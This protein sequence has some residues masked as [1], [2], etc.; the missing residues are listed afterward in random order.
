MDNKLNQLRVLIVDR[1]VHIRQLM[2][3]ILQSIGAQA[4]DMANSAE[5]AFERY[6]T[7]QYDV[8]FTDSE[9]EPVSGLDLVD[10]I[11]GSAKSPNPYVPIIMLSARSDVDYVRL[12]RDHGVTEFLAKPF[13]VDTVM[14]HV[15]AI[16]E[17]PR[18]FVRTR[19]YFGPD[20]RRKS[21]FDY[22]GPERRQSILEKVKL[23]KRDISN[24]QRAA[25]ANKKRSI[26]EIMG[27]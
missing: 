1:N 4:I 26:D 6:C 11:R 16:I 10:M 7:N 15:T 17:N 24:Q 14:K 22:K 9:L 3:T 23:S 18:P 27:D 19:S 25:L 20:R 12:A 21:S 13:T 2:W 5:A 8:V